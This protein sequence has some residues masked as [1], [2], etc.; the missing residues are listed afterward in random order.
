MYDIRP[1]TIIG[2]H[3]CDASVADKLI[4]HPDDIK[5]STEKFDWLGHGLYF[6]ENNYTRA[7]QWAEEKKARGKIITPAVVGAVIQ[8][9][10]CCDFLDSKF[11]NMIQFYYEIMEE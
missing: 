1:N 5:I 2:F 9:G 7:M 4:N 6:W 11:I 10:Q 3:G 8:L